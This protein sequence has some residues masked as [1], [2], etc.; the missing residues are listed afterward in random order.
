[1]GG[2]D[3]DA[4]PLRCRDCFVPPE[5]GLAMTGSL[6]GGPNGR[7]QASESQTDQ[8]PEMTE[9]G[10]YG[11]HL[12]IS[13]QPSF[14]HRRA[15]HDVSPS[16]VE[17]T[18]HLGD[19]EESTLADLKPRHRIAAIDTETTGVGSETMMEYETIQRRKGLG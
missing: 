6:G 7:S 18:E 13:K 10:P 19:S 2:R 1:M 5:E 8:Q 15:L 9:N 17:T 14:Q 3:D 16:Q 4:T 11:L 12:R